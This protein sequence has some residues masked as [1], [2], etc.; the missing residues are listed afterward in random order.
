MSYFWGYLL[1]TCS[2]ILAIIIFLVGRQSYILRP[3]LGSVL[4]TTL[5]IVKEAIKKSWRPALSSLFLDHWLDRAKQCYGGTY[6]NWEVEDVKKVYRLLP[7]FGTFILYWTVYNQVSVRDI[8]LPS[9]KPSCHPPFLLSH[10]LLLFLCIAPF[11]SHPFSPFLS[12]LP[13]ILSLLHPPS[14][15]HP[16]APHPLHSPYNPSHIPCFQQV[17]LSPSNQISSP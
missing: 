12:F 4:A 16:I 10:P 2:L 11:L 17:S 8:V 7:I 1:P 14:L 15:Y 3:S 13:V 6:S 5:S 9:G